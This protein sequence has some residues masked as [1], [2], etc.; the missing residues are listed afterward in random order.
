[1][2]GDENSLLAQ[3]QQLAKRERESADE[4]TRQIHQDRIEQ[5]TRFVEKH[6]PE[7]SRHLALMLGQSP[8]DPLFATRTWELSKAGEEEIEFNRDNALMVSTSF[9]P[10]L[11]TNLEGHAVGVSHFY[12]SD[13]YSFGL[14]CGGHNWAGFGNLADFGRL[15]L[16]LPQTFLWSKVELSQYARENQSEGHTDTQ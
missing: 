13:R 10:K 11:V 15:T 12:Q 14:S 6:S 3:A 1:M 16:E 7:C 8:E 9:L 4:A 2:N 5:V